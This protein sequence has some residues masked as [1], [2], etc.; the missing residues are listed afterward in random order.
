MP[1]H[2]YENMV[3]LIPSQLSTKY[4]DALN[5]LHDEITV[6]F[7]NTMRKARGKAACHLQ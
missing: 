4:A 5:E 2:L 3:K 6:E 1:Q 7:E